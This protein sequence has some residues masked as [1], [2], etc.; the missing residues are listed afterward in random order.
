MEVS[1]FEFQATKP[2]RPLCEPK[3]AK[4]LVV[5]VEHIFSYT[6]THAMPEIPEVA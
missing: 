3:M 6:T 5:S 2:T 1:L 4:G